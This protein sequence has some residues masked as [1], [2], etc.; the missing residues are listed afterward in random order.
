MCALPVVQVPNLIAPVEKGLVLLNPRA[1]PRRPRGETWGGGCGGVGG[2]RVDRARDRPEERQATAGAHPLGLWGSSD[3]SAIP[4]PS[5]AS[6]SSLS[7]SLMQ[8]HPPQ[9]PPKTYLRPASCAGDLHVLWPCAQ[10][11]SLVPSSVS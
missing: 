10:R 2:V 5:T 6:S 4:V 11:K 3:G 9:N 1:S 8:E 7:S